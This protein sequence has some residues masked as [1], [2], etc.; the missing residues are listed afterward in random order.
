MEACDMEQ[1][2]TMVYTV[3]EPQKKLP[4]FKPGKW[5]ISAQ[6]RIALYGHDAKSMKNF[7]LHFD[8]ENQCANPSTVY[9]FVEVWIPMEKYTC[10]VQSA[11][12]QDRVLDPAELDLEPGQDEPEL[13]FFTCACIA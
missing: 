9:G 6:H 10:E 1:Q 3:A 12:S 11:Q 13:C 4:V 5:S 8:C 2:T 7:T